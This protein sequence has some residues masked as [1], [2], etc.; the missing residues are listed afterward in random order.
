LGLLPNLKEGYR[1]SCGTGSHRVRLLRRADG[2]LRR[3]QGKVMDRQDTR[4]FEVG[5][6][7]GRRVTSSRS[8]SMK[9]EPKM[10]G[11]TYEG[12]DRKD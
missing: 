7:R 10:F 9:G 2:V 5:S 4:R 3:F 1:I 6:R 12:S 8:A 11:Y